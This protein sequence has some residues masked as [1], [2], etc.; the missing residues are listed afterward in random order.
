MNKYHSKKPATFGWGFL[1]II[2]TAFTLSESLENTFISGYM[3]SSKN[4]ICVFGVQDDCYPINSL[5]C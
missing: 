1:R 3:T 5:H 2:M 4:S